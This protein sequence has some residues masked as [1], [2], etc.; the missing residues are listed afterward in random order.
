MF[1]LPPFDP[2]FEIAVS[3]HG[4]SKGIEQVDGPQF[5]PKAYLQAG[6]LQ[7]G[8]Q[9]KNVTS[10]TA[11]G[12]ASAFLNF[13]RSFGTFAVT[14]GAAYKVQTGTKGSTDSD[15]FEFTGGVSR[16]FGKVSLKVTAVYSPDDLGGT[17]QSLYVEGG[18]SF[19]LTKT[20]RLSANL[21]RRTRENAPDY[22]S[23]NVGAAETLFRGFSVDLRYYR[24]N[25]ANLGDVYRQ[26]VVLAG[27]LSF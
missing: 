5:I 17:R 7:V 4:M 9:W 16:K 22:V 12:E 13:N 24:T 26:R 25:R 8:G 3:S 27:R 10:T 11:G 1:D 21:G 23:M 18:P 15:S 19:D 2:G 6:D 20:L 14:A